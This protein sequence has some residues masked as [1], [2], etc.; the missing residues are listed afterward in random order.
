MIPNA[1]QGFGRVDVCG[2]GR[3]AVGPTTQLIVQDEG[4][5]ARH[6]RRI[7]HHGHRSGGEDQAPQGHARLDRPARRRPAKRPGPDRQAR[8]WNRASR[9]PGQGTSA[10]GFDR[11]N[12]VEQIV[13]DNP[14]A[15]SVTVRVR[16]FRAAQFAQSSPWLFA[17]SSS[18]LQS[19]RARFAVCSAESSSAVNRRAT[20]PPVTRCQNEAGGGGHASI[21]TSSGRFGRR[22]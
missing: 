8:R 21:G 17:R 4:D 2:R 13:W 7:D 5:R 14:P 10:G 19:A 9:Q 11:T 20:S 18:V 3:S 1:N 12:N 15:G 16:A 22:R 6:R